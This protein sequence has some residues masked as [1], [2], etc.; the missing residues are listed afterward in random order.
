MHSN[1]KA[2]TIKLSILL[3]LILPFKSSAQ[4]DSLTLIFDNNEID[5]SLDSMPSI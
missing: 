1:W 2:N 4:V 5:D 3:L